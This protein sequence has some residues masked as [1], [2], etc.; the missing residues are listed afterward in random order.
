MAFSSKYVYGFQK[1]FY[2]KQEL[3]KTNLD[4]DPIWWSYTNYCLIEKVAA[5]NFKCFQNGRFLALQPLN[6]HDLLLLEVNV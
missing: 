1:S 3:W 5:D 4:G 6:R 2:Y